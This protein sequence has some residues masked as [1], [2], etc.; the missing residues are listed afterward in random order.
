MPQGS[1][2]PLAGNSCRLGAFAWHLTYPG[3]SVDCIACV[4]FEHS[5]IR[6]GSLYE[7]TRVS[8]ATL[9]SPSGACVDLR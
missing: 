5:D 8:F 4:S 7:V 9:L 1:A 6:E 3:S 2:R